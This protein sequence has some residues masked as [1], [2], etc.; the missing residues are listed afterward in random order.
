[1]RDVASSQDPTFLAQVHVLEKYNQIT[2]GL[3]KCFSVPGLTGT[4][5][6]W[7]DT[8]LTALLK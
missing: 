2:G 7:Q 4:G 5:S 8:F 6:R 1:M 3:S